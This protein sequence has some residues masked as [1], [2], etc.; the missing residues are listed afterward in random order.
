MSEPIAATGRE[1]WHCR[2]R[3]S[4]DRTF[5]IADGEELSFGEA[6]VRMRR[7]AAGLRSIGVGSGARVLVGMEN[8]TR[9]WLAHAA[10]R[11]L[12]AVVVPLMPGLTAPELCFQINHSV[13]AT[14]V[15][16][17]SLATVL[18]PHLDECI[19]LNQVVLTGGEHP[20]VRLPVR[21]FEEVAGCAEEDL[22]EPAG[23]GAHSP[24]L[25]IYTSGSTGR[26]KGVV[27]PAGATPSAG[28]QYSERFGVG[29]E[30]VYFLPM[31]MAHAIGAITAQ[32]IAMQTGCRMVIVP[33]FRPSRFWDQVC[34]S[35]STVSILFP[36]Q[37]NLLLELEESA[38]PAADIP[39]RLVI[40][41]VYSA[42]FEERF[43]SLCGISWGM[44]ETGASS[45]GS[46]PGYRGERGE[47]FVGTPM[48]GVEIAVMSPRREI[49]PAG[50]VGE[51]CLRHPDVMLEYLDAPAAT[52]ATL[53]DGWVHSGDLGTIEPDGGLRFQGRIK[54]MIKRSGENVS[55]EELEIELEQHEA[56]GE[57]VVIGVPDRLRTE[58]IAATVVMRDPA[59]DP[60][61]LVAFLEGRVARWKLPR[62][63]A[64]TDQPLPR[65]GNGKIDRRT[66][67]DAFDPASCWDRGEGAKR[68]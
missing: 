20:D 16:D 27:V 36:A 38:P 15:L 1:A 44:T 17:D 32:G 35:G 59:C 31:P 13:A 14:I 65:L 10:L 53:I 9:A 50:E 8:S 34:S 39:L 45:T 2:V 3:Q 40:T 11:E 68:T 61:E 67:L 33:R 18:L 12:G 42:A 29:A 47:G 28:F 58:E 60:A 57:V 66:I 6:D 49:L 30:D 19:H 7:L 21:S 37:Q 52:A 25:I 43:G 4:P 26:P 51:I 48:A 41:H 24:A 22:P 5:L 62:Y 63:I 23:F 64:V 46:A 55:P 56:V 54:N